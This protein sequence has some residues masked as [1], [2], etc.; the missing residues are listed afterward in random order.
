MNVALPRGEE[1]QEMASAS[2]PGQRQLRQPMLP[3]H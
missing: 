2:S 3:C 1:G